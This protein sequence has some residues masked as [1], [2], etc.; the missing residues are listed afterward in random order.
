MIELMC[1]GSCLGLFFICVVLA[2][3]IVALKFR[4]DELEH[5]LFG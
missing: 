2:T 5:R 4:I 3:M 1:L